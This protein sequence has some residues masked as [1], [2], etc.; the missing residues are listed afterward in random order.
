[1]KKKEY[2]LDQQEDFNLEEKNEKENYTILEKIIKINLGKKKIIT[3]IRKQ[4]TII[5]F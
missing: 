4:K 3:R 1:M 5:I 2:K